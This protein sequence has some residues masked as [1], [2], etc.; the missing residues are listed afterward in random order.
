MDTDV[1]DQTSTSIEVPVANES[2]STELAITMP[3]DLPANVDLKKAKDL[4]TK[5]KIEDSNAILSYGVGAQSKISG[6]SDQMLQQVRSKDAGE[7]GNNLQDLLFKI[8]DLD[9]GSF[10]SNKG[11]FLHKLFNSAQKFMAKYDTLEKQI[12]KIVDQLNSAK[13]TISKDIVTLDQLFKKNEEYMGDLDVFIAAGMFK[14]QELN[15]VIRPKIEEEVRSSND[16][17]S[18]QKL[19]DFNQFVN[20]FEKKIHD[21]KLSRQIAIQTGPQIRLIQNNDQALAEKIQSSI[22]T[23]IPL[24]K[25]QVVIALSLLNQKKAIGVQKAVA[26]ATNDL[27]SKNSELLKQ[28]SIEAATELERGIVDIET[29]QKTTEDLISTIDETIRIQQEGRAKR[30]EA[31][32]TLIEL[33]GK[34]KEKLMSTSQVR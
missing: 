26:D 33:E 16:P 17:A 4:A 22:L 11:G 3:A 29:L 27:L 7:V 31:E 6:F 25:S 1:K 20:R 13:M 5:I 8:K 30:V 10:T 14:L 15:E 19:N 21:L 2:G 12:D 28:N 18:A 24:W 34:V 23:T 32:K 9:V